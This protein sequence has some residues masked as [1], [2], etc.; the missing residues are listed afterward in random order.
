MERQKSFEMLAASG[1][2][3]GMR[4][5]FPPDKAVR[6]AEVLL[7]EDITVFE[8]TMN[9]PQA[10]DTMQAI[11]RAFGDDASVGMGTVLTTEQAQRVID[12]GGDIII[13]P[14]FSPAVVEM[15]HNAGLMALP[16]V[17]TPTEC[18]NAWEMGC[19]IL[20][21]F[22]IGPLGLDYFKSLR[23]PL[24]HIKFMCNGGMSAANAGDFLRAGATACGMAGW[25]TGDG[26]MPIETI[27]D[28]ARTLRRI[29]A[30]VRSG[31][32]QPVEI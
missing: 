14:S 22:P 19:E 30:E 16:G 9:S 32:P 1:L 4:G 31:Q 2:M 17:I 21:I 23:G 11:K 3:A 28:R 29:V 6:I 5:D 13:A 12:A 15:A 25:L 20:K 26:S 18:V 8:P 10:I 27:Q 24:N 7:K